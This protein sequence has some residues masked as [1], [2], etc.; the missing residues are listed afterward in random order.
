MEG[1]NHFL[2]HEDYSM[3][4]T[5]DIDCCET[6]IA[7]FTGITVSR[8]ALRNAACQLQTYHNTLA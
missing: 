2:S 1:E 7:E 6:V 3:E 8:C 5:H 4:P